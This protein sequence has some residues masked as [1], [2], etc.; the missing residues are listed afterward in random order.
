[1]FIRNLSRPRWPFI[2][3]GLWRVMVGIGRRVRQPSSS[4]FAFGHSK[5]GRLH[6]FALCIGPLLL[7]GI[8]NPYGQSCRQRFLGS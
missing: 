3:V 6:T 5:G 7:C 4:R 2:Y 1:M 8:Y